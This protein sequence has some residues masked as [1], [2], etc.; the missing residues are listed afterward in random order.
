MQVILGPTAAS[1]LKKRASSGAAAKDSDADGGTEVYFC[2][3]FYDAI[4][5]K[6]TPLHKHPAY[7][8]AGIDAEADG[9]LL[10]GDDNGD[11]SEDSEWEAHGSNGEDGSGSR[12]SQKRRR[13][14]NS[15]SGA[16]AKKGKRA[17]RKPPATRVPKPAPVPISIGSAKVAAHVGE[18]VLDLARA[19]LHVSATPKG[20]EEGGLPCREVEF[21]TICEFVRAQLSSGMGSCL[22][23]SGVPGTGKTATI[24]TV[25]TALQAERDAGEI[26][27]FQFIE[28]N[29]MSLTT[30][31]Q[32]YTELWQQ[33]R[34][35]KGKK[36][37]PAHAL[38]LLRKRFTT[39]SPRRQFTVVLVDELDQLWTRKQDVMYNLFD[40]PNNRHSRLVVVAVANT[41]DLPERVLVKRV[42]SR[43]G[44]QRLT[45]QPYTHEQLVTI[46]T[47]RLQGVQAFSVKAM[48]LCARKVAALSGDARRA[49][50]I[51]RRAAEIA[52]ATGAEVDTSIIQE[53]LKEMNSSPTMLAMA[54]CSI[55]ER[56]FLVAILSEFRK[57]GV[58]EAMFSD[59][60][61]THVSFCRIRGLEPPS[62]S[63]LAA[64]CARLG[65]CRLL[66]VEAGEMDVHQRVRINCNL[67]DVY[68]ALKDDPT[69]KAMRDYDANTGGTGGGG[70]AGVG[71]L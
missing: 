15:S 44:M 17:A 62:T 11:S 36:A 57:S 24:R 39:P 64:V 49:L 7:T 71:S 4:S 50:D 27:K 34:D 8:G 18:D 54:N 63:T 14:V 6:F 22:F 70:A 58:E 55:H 48:E 46:V 60:Y 37:T 42:S 65:A 10:D 19:R 9:Y 45:F 23:V 47:M 2:R 25:A 68:F 67:D 51:C 33:V 61:N 28:I 69:V 13:S 43:I 30:P 5:N 41:M 38:E 31:Q 59:L 40:W 3:T 53:A 16:A 29:G 56:L 1:A 20:A 32:I 26:H 35:K 12:S 66:L 21:F 52:Q